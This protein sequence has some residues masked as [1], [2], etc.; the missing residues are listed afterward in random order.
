MSSWGIILPFIHWGLSVL[1]IQFSMG[2]FEMLKAENH[3]GMEE[4]VGKSSQFYGNPN[5]DLI[6][7][8][9]NQYMGT[10]VAG[11]FIM[12]N[13]IK[14]DDLGVPLFQEPLVLNGGTCVGNQSWNFP[15][16]HL[17]T[18]QSHQIEATE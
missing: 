7:E 11:W 15:L 6:K 5:W 2:G 3:V 4:L 1:R 9:E 14:I 18:E 10:P 8:A 12:E 16:S 13:P 17:I